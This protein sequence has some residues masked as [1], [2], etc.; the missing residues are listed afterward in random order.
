MASRE[1]F[2]VLVSHMTYLKNI[3]NAFKES[4]ERFRT[5]IESSPHLIVL[6]NTKGVVT[7]CNS[8]LEDLCGCK[9]EEIIGRH[10]SS[11]KFLRDKNI[12]EYTRI[13]LSVIKNR[14]SESFEVEWRQKDGSRRVGVV[15]VRPVEENGGVLGVMAIL[16]EITEKKSFEEKRRETE[17]KMATLMENLP[18]M[19]YRMLNDMHWT[20]EFVS[21]GCFSLTGYRPSDLIGNRKISF[22][23]LIHPY[24]RKTVWSEILKSLKSGK[25]FEMIYRIITKSG[26]EKWVWEKGTGI[27]KED[28]KL[29]SLEGFV[30]DISSERRAREE[31]RKT[32]NEL[33]RLANHLQSVKEDEWAS[34][35]REIHDEMS[36][37]L[38]SLKMDLS[39]LC[40]DSTDREVRIPSRDIKSMIS[41]VDKVLQNVKQ[42]CT[43]LRP[44]LLD[45]L[46]L[47]A[48]IEWQAEEFQKRSDIKCIVHFGN[49][50]IKCDERITVTI[51]RIFQEA[52]TNIIRHAEA[53]EVRVSLREE[54]NRLTF[55]VKDN[56]MGIAET[57][58][59]K[60][61]SFGLIG[62][63]ERVISLGG[64]FEIKGKKKE[65]TTVTVE[66]PL[67]KEGI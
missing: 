27:F 59:S 24:D 64:H 10:L 25:P 63:R 56:G 28:G 17:R 45:D 5:I 35:A 26:E 6:L 53:T 62:M 16:S 47:V 49:K 22:N 65:G 3:E 41:L 43:R 2:P 40:G 51:F 21:Q 50:D 4:K 42:I 11:L 32:S 23:K 66:I 19:A 1:K 8:V 48:A 18:G 52:L 54:K 39:L 67:G 61:G 55:I 20:M 57:D 15:R 13:F 37:N 60:P 34:I 58:I 31:L 30:L 14:N 33:R 46:G 29:V 44:A 12:H 9:R 36:Q 38:T 7:A